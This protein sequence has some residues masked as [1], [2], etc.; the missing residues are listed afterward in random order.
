M[1][2]QFPLLLVNGRFATF[3]QGSPKDVAQCVA[4]LMRTP[5][6]FRD[7]LPDLGIDRLAFRRNGPDLDEIERQI[8]TYEPRAVAL[9]ESDPSL[10]EDAL[11]EVGVKLANR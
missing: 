4:V 2:L 6:G 7:D 8:T 11:S 9:V 5:R 1:P 3:E 10:L